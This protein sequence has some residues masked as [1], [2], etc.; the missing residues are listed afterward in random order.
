M[1]PDDFCA[2]ATGH[3]PN[4][5]RTA[6]ANTPFS[7]LSI[8]SSVAG[9]NPSAAFRAYKALR[10]NELSVCKRIVPSVGLEMLFDDLLVGGVRPRRPHRRLDGLLDPFV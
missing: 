4:R 6:A 2:C 9:D 5:A 7:T 1:R 10:F 8:F 3:R